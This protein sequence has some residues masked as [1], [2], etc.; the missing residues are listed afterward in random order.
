[1]RSKTILAAA[2]YLI[3]TLLFCVVLEITSVFAQSQKPLKSDLAEGKLVFVQKCEACHFDLSGDKKIGPGLAGL[4][5]RGRFKNGMPA[6]EYHLQRII[7]RGGKN[8]PSSRD[9][10]NG[11]QLRDLI[12][13]LKTL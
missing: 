10:L 1:M 9:S 7:E 6:D 13:Y 2:L 8:M 12:A 11:R 5:K 3:F 4:M